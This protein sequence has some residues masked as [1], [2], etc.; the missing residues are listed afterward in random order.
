MYKTIYPLKDATLYSQFSTQNTGVDQILEIAKSTI[1]APSI[2]GDETVYF[3]DTYNSRILIQFDLS[4][5]S[6]SI[7]SGKINSNAQYFLVLKATE[8][9]N[10]PIS[11]TLYAY[12]T[13]GS[14]TNGTGY[15]N[16]NPIITNG[17]SWKYQ[18]S[19]VDGVLWPTASYASTATG[20]FGTIPGGGNW[21][22][23]SVCSQGFNHEE[24]DV[25]MD[26]TGIVRKWI[27]GSIDN[28]GFVVKLS[29]VQE[30]NLDI[31][32]SI[33]FF[34]L[35]SHTIFLPRLEVYWDNTVLSGTG[36]FTEVSSD[37]FIL[38]A[39]NMRIEY[40]EQ[41]K[42]KIR[43]GARD[44]YPTRTYS[45]SSNYT[46]SKRL[47]TGSYFQIQDVETDEIIIPFNTLGT[48]VSCDSN[49]NYIQLD[50][51]SLMC[52]RYYKLIFKSEFD[53]ADTV[54]MIDDNFIFR[55]TR[56]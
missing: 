12:P 13:S 10:L 24:P 53:G 52:E 23:S 3:S 5:I 49:G 39:K 45:T 40:K 36:S 17:T 25:R 6:S 14:W 55:V 42:P 46:V 50:M 34:S 28:N 21:Y 32:G 26:V 31:L 35:E 22:T 51:N 38:Y 11:Y 9:F 7:V 15:F 37:D 44:R 20:S 56:S 33:K 8:A 16:N 18:Q 43:L 19:K 47:P 30:Q 1:G 4:D 54:R 41:E 48:R 29:D 2:E 27:S